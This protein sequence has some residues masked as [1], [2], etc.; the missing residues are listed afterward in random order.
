[1]PTF[2][3]DPNPQAIYAMIK[4]RGLL[5]RAADYASKAVA[6]RG[7]TP[8]VAHAKVDTVKG[9]LPSLLNEE[10]KKTIG[11]IDDAHALVR[12][13]DSGAAGERRGEIWRLLQRGTGRWNNENLSSELKPSFYK[14]VAGGKK[15]P[16][17]KILD[18]ASAALES[19]LAP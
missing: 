17:A 8:V 11:T 15:M 10:G 6:K 16:G 14:P 18:P 5:G 13:L 12:E 19:K 9:W 4:R 3:A 7:G 2:S 1:M